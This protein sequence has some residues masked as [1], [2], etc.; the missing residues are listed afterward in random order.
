MQ[1]VSWFSPNGIYGIPSVRSGFAVFKRGL[2]AQIFFP[3]DRTNL[4]ALDRNVLSILATHFKELVK[5]ER[6]ELAILG[7]ADHR[8]G[9]VYNRNLGQGRADSVTEELNRL[10]RDEKNFSS[11]TGISMGEWVAAQ[12]TK[13]PTLLALDRRV[14]IW[15]AAA[16]YELPPLDRKPYSLRIVYREFKKHKNAYSGPDGKGADSYDQGLEALGDLWV[17]DLNGRFRGMAIGA[18]D[19]RKRQSR[20]VDATHRVNGVAIDQSYTYKLGWNSEIESWKTTVKYA[21]GVPEPVVA[22]HFSDQ[23]DMVGRKSRKVGAV[24]ISRE[25]ADKNPFLFPAPLSPTP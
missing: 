19:I 6:V 9:Y 5:R 15:V 23:T 4:D 21:W 22:V 17:G 18:E 13:D 24:F 14:D 10:L 2:I 7:H 12:G 11:F 16:A 3:T 8:K 20:Y 25:K 1:L